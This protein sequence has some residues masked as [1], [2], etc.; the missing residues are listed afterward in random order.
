MFVA[1]QFK[2]NRQWKGGGNCIPHCH[3]RCQDR[4]FPSHAWVTHHDRNITFRE[5]LLNYF[6]LIRSLLL[7]LVSTFRWY[8]IMLLYCYPSWASISLSIFCIIPILKSW[9]HLINRVDAYFRQLSAI[10]PQEEK[11]SPYSVN[12]ISRLISS[13][14]E[15]RRYLSWKISQHFIPFS[16]NPFRSW[17]KMS[18]PPRCRKRFCIITINSR[19]ASW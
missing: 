17:P 2:S 8:I 10:S 4:V 15:A 7:L 9:G 12:I 14:L 1:A 6:L 13:N 11:S 5:C 16:L 19:F 18:S 3:Y